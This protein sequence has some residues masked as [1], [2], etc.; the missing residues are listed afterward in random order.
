MATLRASVTVSGDSPGDDATI[1][2]DGS[3]TPVTANGLTGYLP[4][5]G[6]RLLIDRVG[7]TLEVLQFLN[8][9]TVP[10]IGEDALSDLTA[11]VSANSDLLSD[12]DTAIAANSNTL[13]NY[14]ATND[15]VVSGLQS[16]YDALSGLGEAGVE[17][18]YMYVGDDPGLSTV[19]MVQISTYV[20]QGLFAGD[21]GTLSDYFGLVNADDM[22]D[23]TFSG[24]Q[25]PP[26][27]T[28]YNAFTAAGLLAEPWYA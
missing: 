18:D 21:S 7:S 8:R 23:L 15:Q 4:T 24:S 6:D 12:H 13:T 9:G 2:I 10:Y 1:L 26:M 27:T 17:E 3:D 19:K 20:Q 22:G 25:L 11:Q 28:F 14:M 16:G 5:A